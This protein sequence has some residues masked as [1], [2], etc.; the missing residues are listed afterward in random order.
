MKQVSTAFDFGMRLKS[1]REKVGLSQTQVATRL[2]LTRATVSSYERNLITP[3]V[4][5]LEKFSMLY[6]VT[7]DYLLGI[8]KRPCIVLDNLTPRQIATIETM[9]NSILT[10]FHMTNKELN[11]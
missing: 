9:L 7:T 11:L 2:N 5:V 3:S 8:D 10:E 1:L 6:H 4:D